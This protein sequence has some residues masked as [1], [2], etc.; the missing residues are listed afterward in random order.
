MMNKKIL[1][2]FLLTFC[3]FVTVISAQ[4]IAPPKP[5]GVLPNENQLNWQENN[6][7]A[8]IHFGLNTFTD[9]EWGYGDE[10]PALFNPKHF[11]ADQIVR[12]IKQGGFTG[13][14]LTCKHHDGFCLWPTK[15]TEHNITKSP[16]RNGKGD[17]VKEIE[18]A[19]RKYGLRFGVYLSPWDRNNPSY[20]T[21][22]YVNKIYR[23]QLKELL[24][25]Y[26]PVF[27][28]WHDGANGGD[29]YYGGAREERKIDR[30]TYYN[31]P[32]VWQL[33]RKLQP[34]ALIFGD[35]GADLRWVGN[36][37]GYAGIPCWQTFTPISNIPGKA[38]SNGTIKSELSTNGT[39]NGRY[40]MP[41]ESDLSIRP[42]WFWHQS[43]NDK[44]RSV[45]DLWKHYL[46]TVGRGAALILNVPPD[47]D[48]L[49]YKTDS[50]NLKE[51]GDVLKETFAVNL[52]KGARIKASNV[53]GNDNKHY[54]TKNLLDNDQFSYWATD[55]DIH[56][57]QLTITLPE[58]RTFD[59]IRLKENTKLGQRIDSVSIDAFID[60]QWQ[61]IAGANSIGSERLVLLNK[62]ITTNKLR[63]TVV[64]SPVCV[65]LSDFALF[66]Q[67]D[68]SEYETV[69]K[70]EKTVSKS[71]WKI[72]NI[73]N[74]NAIIDNNSATF[75]QSNNANFPQNVIVDLG[76]TKTIS[77]FSYLP[78]QDNQTG[79]IIDRYELSAS[80][81]GKT[82]SKLSSGEFSNIKA[83]LNLQTVTFSA[84]VNARYFKFGI[85]HTV[86][87]QS[88]TIAEL[89][90]E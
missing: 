80:A 28:I 68:L 46:V 29:G 8:F 57:P 52:A 24:T 5:Y 56:T 62:K 47:R 25:N 39:R 51:F 3:L 34:H 77:S 44:V 70:K 21:Q 11:D 49:V 4:K 90:F 72:T 31:W 73:K 66:S 87:N 18:E 63:L 86:D 40:W 7:Y 26:G 41:A 58:A 50:I 59:I 13:I 15:T 20:G 79:G 54:G 38:P 64:K 71:D 1:F 55:D 22:D 74:A 83:S 36:E 9:K 75:W 67:P 65:A 88:P 32:S 35:I 10:D 61:N 16:F 2:A 23:E 85:L 42:G 12:S 33:E 30:T 6:L 76:K 14:V 60:N 19:C 78:R 37:Q 89:G 45:A 82:W 81:D 27:E 17:L 69:R 48:G 43:Q 84:T 53:R